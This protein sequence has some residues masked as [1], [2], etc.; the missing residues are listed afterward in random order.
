MENIRRK[1]IY[2]F[3]VMG[4]IYLIVL[5]MVNIHLAKYLIGAFE[6]TL[7][8]ILIFNLFTFAKWNKLDLAS[9]M[10]LGLLL[11]FYS[12]LFVEGGINNTGIIWLFT[13]P[14]AAFFFKGKIR[15]ITWVSAFI[16]SITTCYCLSKKGLLVLPH[17]DHFLLIYFFAFL[18]I[19]AFVYSYENIRNDSEDVIL[20]KTKKL[21]E[22]NKELEYLSTHDALT[23]IYNR[24]FIMKCLRDEFYRF[25]RYEGIFSVMLIDIDNFKNIN[26][27]RGHQTGDT[28]LTRVA[29]IFLDYQLRGVDFFGRYGGDEF[30]IILPNTDQEGARNVAEK[31]CDSI[32]NEFF[33]DALTNERMSVSVSI[34]ISTI[35]KGKNQ[36]RLLCEADMALYTSKKNGRDRVTVFS[37]DLIATTQEYLEKLENK[38][39]ACYS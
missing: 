20:S 7:A 28:I 23:C 36:N 29:K 1:T 10:I 13:Y 22:L 19:T 6:F 31:L 14:I 30:I 21:E 5:G 37:P 33:V 35:M 38:Y 8:G 3:S 17:E 4:A 39:Q 9:T 26:D 18:L 24:R 2:C 32:R 11:A 34:G 27:T 16:V 25:S 15:G 12:Y